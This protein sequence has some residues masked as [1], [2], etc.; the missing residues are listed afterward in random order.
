MISTQLPKH[1][2]AD[3]RAGLRRTTALLA[4]ASWI[5]VKSDRAIVIEGG[6]G[7]GKS[8]AA[9][10]AHQFSRNRC[11]PSES[12]P[13]AWP[14]WCDARLVSA[15][16]GFEYRLPDDWRRFDASPLVVLDDVGCED[17][18]QQMGALLER[19]W[20]VA[21]GRVVITTNLNADDFKRRYGER[22]FS[23]V[24]TSRWVRSADPDFRASPPRGEVFRRPED[25][26]ACECVDRIR[27]EE[28]A[29]HE[30]E[31]WEAERLERE[32]RMTEVMARV[33]EI[34]GAKRFAKAAV[35]DDA[36]TVGARIRRQ[37][38]ELSKKQGE[39]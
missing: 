35:G 5:E 20:N 16:V 29:V 36:A 38:E 1:I 2:M 30:E 6:T 23:R 31:L 21:N 24:A 37:L 10:W 27:A 11:R 13:T 17:E 25:E 7:A 4:V 12:G 14:V 18:P 19:V 15:M 34:T 33:A 3:M 28:K 26:T 8:L 32:R 9:A 39:E 22:V